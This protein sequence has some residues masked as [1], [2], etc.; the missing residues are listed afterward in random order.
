MRIE[1]H[2]TLI[3]DRVRNEAFGRALAAVIRRGERAPEGLVA[4]A[5]GDQRPVV[6]DAHR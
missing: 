3:A 6:F 4:H 2:R 1:Y 5:V